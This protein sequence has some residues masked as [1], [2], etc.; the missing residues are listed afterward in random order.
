M[1]CIG[2][3][4]ERFLKNKDSC[5][6]SKKTRVGWYCIWREIN[7]FDMSISALSQ[8]GKGSWLVFKF[9]FTA[10][11][12]FP[13]VNEL[14]MMHHVFL[15]IAKLA[16]KLEPNLHN[17][18]YCELSVFWQDHH[19]IEHSQKGCIIEKKCTCARKGAKGE[20]KE[21]K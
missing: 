7:S 19:D 4:E 2:S 17:C 1:F 20:I 9:S 10:K 11:L 14:L 5:L 3:E 16:K 8:E 13:S 15:R 12:F 21:V 6:S 18:C